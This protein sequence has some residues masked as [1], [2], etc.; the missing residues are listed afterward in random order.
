MR[1]SQHRCWRWRRARRMSRARDF[2]ALNGPGPNA[3]CSDPLGGRASRRRRNHQ[4][5]PHG[6]GS[7]Q[8]PTTPP[9]PPVP[10]RTNLGSA[11]GREN[12]HSGCGV[13]HRRAGPYRPTDDGPRLDLRHSQTPNIAASTT[14]QMTTR[15][16]SP[17]TISSS[18]GTRLHSNLQLRVERC[19]TT[20]TAAAATAAMTATPI[21]KPLH[22][23]FRAR[24]LSGGTTPP[25]AV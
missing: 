7:G 11:G 19:M 17:S 24:G 21:A 6:R 13:Y 20:A 2:V 16:I 8:Q 18:G 10:L 9:Q 25:I 22:G 15:A 5:D 12:E 3:P 14:R 23:S 1:C 4:Q